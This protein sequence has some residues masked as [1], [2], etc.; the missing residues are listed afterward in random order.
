MHYSKADSARA[1]KAY[2]GLIGGSRIPSVIDGGLPH[3]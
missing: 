3:N 2:D 1:A